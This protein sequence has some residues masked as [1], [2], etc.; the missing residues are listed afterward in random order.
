[1][2]NICALEAV[3][4]ESGE[5]KDY[6]KHVGMD[7]EALTGLT[8]FTGLGPDNLVNSVNPVQKTMEQF[9]EADNFGSLILPVV[10]NAMDIL[11]V[12]ESKDL[13]GSLLY[14]GIHQKVLLALRQAAYLSLRIRGNSRNMERA[15]L[16]LSDREP[17]LSAR[18]MG[19][20]SAQARGTGAGTSGEAGC[21][22]LHQAEYSP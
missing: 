12:F 6:L 13:M 18:G 5:I 19:E 11:P 16:A 14:Y 22:G 8:G 17:V 2:P 20:E 9:D 10:D 3:K 7:E 1:M 21:K 15:S 4:F